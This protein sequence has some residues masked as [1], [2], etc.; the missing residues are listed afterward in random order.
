MASNGIVLRDIS[1]KDLYYCQPDEKEGEAFSFRMISPSSCVIF[2]R[3][4]Q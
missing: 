1:R 4:Q 3:G 2:S